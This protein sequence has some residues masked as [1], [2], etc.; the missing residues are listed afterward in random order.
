[1]EKTRDQC[2][3]KGEVEGTCVYIDT[4]ETIIVQGPVVK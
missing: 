2:R 1:M 4:I 3:P